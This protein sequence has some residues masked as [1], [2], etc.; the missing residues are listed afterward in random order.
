M[1]GGCLCGAVRY[2][3]R[4]QPYDAHYCHCR[5]CQKISG[6]PAISGAFLSRDAFRFTRG[7]P[8]FYRSSSIVERGF[9]A[10]C[11]TYLLYRPLIA[12]WSDWIIVTIASLDRPDD[13]P[14]PA[15]LRCREPDRVARHRR[16]L[17]ARALR[18]GLRRNP[19]DWGPRGTGGRLGAVRVSETGIGDTTA[20]A[21]ARV[22]EVEMARFRTADG[23][24]AGVSAAVGLAHRQTVRSLTQER[25][26]Q[27]AAHTVGHLVP[28][29]WA[30]FVG[31]ARPEPDLGPAEEP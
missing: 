20:V 27:P 25:P 17:P 11:S 21:W 4:E 24:A 19:R 14:P 8:K 28:E 5:T 13:L 1:E 3:V 2:E 31:G 15:S 30:V 18:G 12:E 9:C 7:A 23:S 10:D 16:R 22:S 26:A 6:A 29:Q